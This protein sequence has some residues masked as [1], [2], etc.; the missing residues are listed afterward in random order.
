MR[1][2][3]VGSGAII[4][5]HLE[6]LTQVGFTVSCIASRPGSESTRRIANDYSAKALDTFRQID[7]TSIDAV[8]IAPAAHALHEPLRHFLEA[9]TPILVEKPALCTVEEY[10]ALGDLQSH[11][12]MVG[13]NRRHY[14]S[15]QT[16]K[17]NL[18][19]KHFNS[20]HLQ[21][22]ENSWNGPLD[23]KG[24][25]EN[26][27]INTVH[28]FD[29]LRYLIEPNEIT[30]LGSKDSERSRYSS[31][32]LFVQGSQISGT[33]QITF[34]TPN[35]Y[36][37]EFSGNG[38]LQVLQPIEVLRKFNGIEIVEPN[39]DFPIR[40]YLPK[41]D[42]NGFEIHK[43]DQDFKPGFFRQAEE[44]ANLVQ[45][46][47]PRISANLFDAMKAVEIAEMIKARFI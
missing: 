37:F 45:G 7:P 1:L 16:I 18:T 31:I 40:R 14:S 8:L 15:V 25:Q 17:T 46:V 9:G 43:V 33:V 32:N 28:M 13:Y 4:P 34:N 20:F 10:L 3:V 12:V 42:E 2:A 21:I 35:S 22:P 11:Q 6:A 36:R 23:T 30:V 41:L 39:S 5:F 26:L 24:R 27:V 19:D 38:C 44:F 47:P 29:L